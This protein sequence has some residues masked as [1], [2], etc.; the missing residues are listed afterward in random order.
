MVLIA[1]PSSSGK[2]TFA[3][4]LGVQL[5][6]NGLKPVTISVDNYFV[7]RSETPRDENGEYNFECLEAIDLNLFNN[8]I[9]ELLDGG[10][11]DVPTFDFKVGTKRYNGEKMHL[12]D[13]EIL[14]IEGIHCLNDK[15]TSSIPMEQKYKIYISD[16]TVLNID[17]C[18]RISTTDTRLLRRIVRDNNYRGYT[19][20]HTLKSWD[21]VNRGEHQNIFPYQENCDAMF[22]SSLIYE[23][24]VLKKH[25][26]PLLEEI[27]NAEP[28]YSEA[29]RLVKFSKYFDDIDEEFIPRNSLMREFIGGSVFEY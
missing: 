24:S 17:Y 27:T 3:K 23:I 19:A 1:G 21:S 25:A 29:K 18:N 11:I 12:A 10:E 26:L 8:H 16:L 9:K 14:V 6:L 15:L 5:R 4:R 22:N 20:L 28:E 7:E 2:T 13:D